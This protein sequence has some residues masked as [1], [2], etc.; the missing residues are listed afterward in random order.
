[1]DED[2]L[3]FGWKF[4]KVDFGGFRKVQLDPEATFEESKLKNHTTIKVQR[5]RLSEI[6]NDQG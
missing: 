4:Y 1:L 2:Q 3:P 5:V 6:N